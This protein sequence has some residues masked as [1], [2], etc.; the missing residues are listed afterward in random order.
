VGAVEV[1]GYPIEPGAHLAGANFFEANLKGANLTSANLRGANLSNANLS[2]A[3]L[4]RAWLSN[5]N[6]TRAYLPKADLS[7]ADLYGADLYGADLYGADL[8]RANLRGAD[9]TRANLRGANLTGANLSGADL[10]GANLTGVGLS[11]VSLRRAKADQDTLWPEGF[12]PVAAGVI[13]QSSSASTT[14]V[15]VELQ[16][17][18]SRPPDS[19]PEPLPAGPA[20][21]VADELGKLA[22]LRDRGVLSE[23]EFEEQKMKLLE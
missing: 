6:L 23:E 7:G 8:T 14:G 1:N 2:N 10:D 3:N 5:A 19:A 22:D 17:A 20:F 4:L 21:S 12:D 16:Q 15:D 13:I 18:D 9:L 11:N